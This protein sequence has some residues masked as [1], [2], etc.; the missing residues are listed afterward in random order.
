MLFARRRARCDS[1]NDSQLNVRSRSRGQ[2]LVEFAMVLPV[3]LFLT[4]GIIDG[5]RMFNANVTLTNG[6]SEAAVFAASNAANAVRTCPTGAVGC[7]GPNMFG[8]NCTTDYSNIA[9]HLIG[10]SNFLDLHQLT[11]ATPTCGPSGAVAP[12]ACVALTTAVKGNV[13][14][15]SATY[16]WTP[17]LAVPLLTPWANGVTL[18]ATTRATILP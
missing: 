18:N 7:P 4:V 17:I 5:A 10:D 14:T 13:V 9:C 1:M 15:V 6:V 12:G 16:L 2:A 8:L 11:M 3:F